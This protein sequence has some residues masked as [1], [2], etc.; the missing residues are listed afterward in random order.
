MKKALLGFLCLSVSISASASIQNLCQQLGDLKHCQGGE[1]KLVQSAL[2]GNKSV[3]RFRFV[4]G[5]ELNL[6]YGS[7]S[8]DL[9]SMLASGTTIK[10]EKYDSFGSLNW[11]ILQTSRGNNDGKV[12]ATLFQ[13]EHRGN[14]YYGYVASKN[15]Q[16]AYDRV[17][18]FLA[19]MNADSSRS[20]TGVDYKGKKYYF[21]WGAA[22]MGDPTLMQNEVKYDV[23][24][25]HDIFTKDIG[26]SYMGTKFLDYKTATGTA[27]K[28]T[29]TDIKSKIQADDMYIQYS[30]GHGSPTGL[31]V[32]V[33]Y[34][35]IRDTVL[36]FN[37]KETVIFIMACHSGALVDSFNKKKAD[38]QNFQANGKNL[39]VM[40][41]SKAN[42]N[43]STGP[44]TDP[45]QP[46]GPTGSAGSAF[47]HALWKALIGH[48]DGQTTGV[49][50]EYLTLEEIRDFSVK[51]TLAV[52]QHTPVHTGSYDAK[53]VMNKVPS[54]RFIDSLGT[55]TE[56][57]S[58]EQIAELVRKLDSEMRL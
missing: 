23:L 20:L 35:Q 4:D 29:W 17:Y 25:T 51:K 54:Q 32:G 21:G 22:G 3:L 44:N 30:S 43:S 26:G 50:D 57:M 47:G 56:G 53:L 52:G 41:S 12:Y 7:Q 27:I 9:K 37:A 2:D 14:V 28:N 15:E 34:D 18:S 46:G 36:S 13:T 1:W 24:H 55:S 31:A 42:E 38:W 5:E 19:G 10:A 8:N 39:F 6:F 16:T 49:K 33:T 45:Q 48:A 11:K 40:A 58:D